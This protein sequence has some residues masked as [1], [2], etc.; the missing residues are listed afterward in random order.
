MVNILDRGQGQSHCD[1]NFTCKN[2]TEVREP[3]V[4]IFQKM[5]NKRKGPEV[6]STY[7]VQ[8]TIKDLGH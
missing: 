3:A 2:A 6:T 7:G 1:G 8:E 4:Q 5:E